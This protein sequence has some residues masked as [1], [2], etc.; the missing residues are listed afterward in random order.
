MPAFH[1]HVLLVLAFFVCLL[2]WVLLFGW[3]F[4]SSLEA[5][6]SCVSIFGVSVGFL[7]DDKS[8][9]ECGWLMH[10]LAFF[11]V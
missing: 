9:V 3:V 4:F 10:S 6:I 5:Y 1:C 2:V 7:P 8:W 11:I